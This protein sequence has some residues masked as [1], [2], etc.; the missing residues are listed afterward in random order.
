[1]KAK[2]TLFKPK[3]RGAG[4]LLLVPLTLVIIH[5]AKSSTKPDPGPSAQEQVDAASNALLIGYA[6]GETSTNVTQNVTLS[7]SGSN[8]VSIR[9]S[10]TAETVIATNGEVTRPVFGES[11]A[12]VTLTATLSKDRCN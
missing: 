2:E 12:M 8:E 10:S 9:W 3:F 11:N 7:T 1:M 4:L 6:A 5:C